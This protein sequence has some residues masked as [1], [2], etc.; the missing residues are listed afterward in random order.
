MICS[1]CGAVT[2]KD[3]CPRC[4]FCIGCYKDTRLVEE[5]IVKEHPNIPRSVIRKTI[6]KLKSR[7]A[8]IKE[9]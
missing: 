2:D 6:E 9:K 8:G 5:L 7:G 4:G 3:I 1:K